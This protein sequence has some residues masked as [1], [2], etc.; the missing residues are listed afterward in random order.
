MLHSYDP[1]DE[2]HICEPTTVSHPSESYGQL[3]A[4]K[5]EFMIP[6]DL[7]VRALSAQER[8]IYPERM[9]SIISRS[10]E[11]RFKISLA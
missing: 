11:S 9:D 7:R 10:V 4:K 1:K 5:K 2:E 3:G 8:H 6:D